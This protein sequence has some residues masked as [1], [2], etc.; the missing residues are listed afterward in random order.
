MQRRFGRRLI[1]GS[2]VVVAL[3]IGALAIIALSMRRRATEDASRESNGT[4]SERFEEARG[5]S[6][7]HDTDSPAEQRVNDTLRPG[8]ESVRQGSSFQEGELAERARQIA[9]GSAR[10]SHR[11]E[12]TDTAASETE[13]EVR[14]YLEDVQYPASKDDLVSAARSNDAPEEFVKR[15]VGLTI[16]EYQSPEEVALAVDTHRASGG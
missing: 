14:R 4:A 9:K 11:G 7:R 3:G 8:V 6:T 12:T 15:L 5:Q 16:R 1:F 13:Q 2:S 10:R